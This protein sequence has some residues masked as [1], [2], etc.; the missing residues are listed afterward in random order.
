MISTDISIKKCIYMK[1]YMQYISSIVQHPASFILSQ[2]GRLIRNEDLRCHV[3]CPHSQQFVVLGHSPVDWREKQGHEENGWWDALR[4][5]R[6]W[7]LNR[8]DQMA[9]ITLPPPVSPSPLPSTA[10]VK[11]PST[12]FPLLQLNIRM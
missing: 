9:K 10:F 3:Q 4:G 12:S 5:K 11:A 8:R 1:G 2:M 6:E 7:A